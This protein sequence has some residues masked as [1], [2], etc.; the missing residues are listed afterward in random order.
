M[1]GSTFFL[2]GFHH[3]AR[4]DTRSVPAPDST[5]ADL[6][7]RHEQC[8]AQIDPVARERIEAPKRHID[9]LRL[10]WFGVVWGDYAQG[11][12]PGDPAGRRSPNTR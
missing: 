5:L 3:G 4:L 1:N 6:E 11:P 10:Q 12:L 2:P 8:I 7:R 9:R